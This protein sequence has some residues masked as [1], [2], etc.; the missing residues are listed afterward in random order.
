MAISDA[1][2]RF[3]SIDV[4]APGR[5][6]DSGVFNESAMGRKFETNT[7]NV[8]APEA[9]IPHG[10]ELPYVLVGDEAFGLSTYLM[11]PY[12]RSGNLNIKKKVFNYRLS[13]ARRVVE[14]AFGILA[15][16]WRIFLLKI[17]TFTLL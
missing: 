3:I 12:P 6:N 16:R 10:P 15:A 17:I 7:F 9:I 14:S 8:P 5:R 11:R 13:R 1:H 2:Y 4:G